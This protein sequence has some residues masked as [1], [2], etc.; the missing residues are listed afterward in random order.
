MPAASSPTT[1]HTQ[2]PAL[3]APLL[4]EGG[5]PT[6]PGDAPVPAARA[7]NLNEPETGWPSADVTRQLTV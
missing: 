7:E 5:A 3:S 1:S 6:G 2:P 4:G